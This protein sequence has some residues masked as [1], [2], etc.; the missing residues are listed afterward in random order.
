MVFPYASLIIFFSTLATREVSSATIMRAEKKNVQRLG[1]A[2]HV[3]T[4]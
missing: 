4:F 2:C 3:S 1:L